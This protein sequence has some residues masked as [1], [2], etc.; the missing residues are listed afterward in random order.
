MTLVLLNNILK[1]KHIPV[2]GIESG[3]T[4]WVV[5]VQAAK[6]EEPVKLIVNNRLNFNFYRTEIEDALR[7]G[8]FTFRVDAES[9]TYTIV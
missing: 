9:R 2:W 4:D 5:H 8:T 1:A 6:D 3:A 7:D